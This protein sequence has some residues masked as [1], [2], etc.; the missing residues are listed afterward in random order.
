MEQVRFSIN[1]N[2]NDAYHSC[3][4][5]YFQNSLQT[6][7]SV[8]EKHFCGLSKYSHFIP[9]DIKR[10][11]QFTWVIYDI[12]YDQIKHILISLADHV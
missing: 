5:L 6:L 12:D 3:S 7:I 10:N 8:S 4:I 1:L 9:V 2:S 11:G